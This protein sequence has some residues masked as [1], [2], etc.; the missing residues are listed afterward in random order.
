MFDKKPFIVRPWALGQ[1]TNKEDIASLP[2]WVKFPKLDL[3][4]WGGDGLSKIASLV[5]IPLATD[6][7][8]QN[9][10]KTNYAR[11]LSEMNLNKEFP[12]KV[13]Y[14]NVFG[15]IETQTVDYEWKPLKCTSCA[16]FAHLKE[17]CRR[18]GRWEWRR[19]ETIIQTTEE[20]VDTEPVKDAT[21]DQGTVQ[22]YPNVQTRCE[23]AQ[24]DPELN[25]EEQ[26]G[27]NM[28]PRSSEVNGRRV[29][30]LDNG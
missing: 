20:H 28:V 9:K 15:E 29:L 13:S 21:P 12:E 30:T 2:V 11:V 23:P 6:V 3:R 27:V 5:G 10:D 19:K 24:I 18:T 26:W 16:M 14:M 17:D 4:Y 8:T 7:A 25:V 1:S 22:E